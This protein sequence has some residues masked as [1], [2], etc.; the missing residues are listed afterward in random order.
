M[1]RAEDNVFAHWIIDKYLNFL[2]KKDFGKI[3]FLG[4]IQNTNEPL[5]ITPNHI[6]WWD[7]FFIYYTVKKHFKRI[8]HILMLEDQ[9]EKYWFFKYT[10]CFGI[11]P[12][13][14]SS[15]IEASD[16]IAEILNEK[17]SCVVIY[18]QGEIEPQD[19][20]PLSLKSGL[21]Y[22]L[23]KAPAE[24][25]LINAAFRIQFGTKRKPNVFYRFSE[26]CKLEHFR[27]HPDA[28][29]DDFRENILK[30]DEEAFAFF[31]QGKE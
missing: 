7:G 27:L 13:N 28:Y 9:L 12:K 25:Q 1:I 2:L 16:Y 31:K 6:S 11:N 20:K 10:G 14:P 17:N 19:K 15:I 26:F 23:R 29:Y 22:F 18:I 8:P 3:I 30:L 4:K 21:K 24:T 5:V